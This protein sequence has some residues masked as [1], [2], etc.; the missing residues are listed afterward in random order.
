MSFRYRVFKSGLP[1]PSS[2][3]LL[4]LCSLLEVTQGG[5]F[6]F[7]FLEEA[8]WRTKLLASES[9]I[10]KSLRYLASCESAGVAKVAQTER[11][12]EL[13]AQIKIR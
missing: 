5:S 6:F 8:W 10:A 13:M 7:F 1:F 2:W 11:T 4:R 9:Q 12:V 3:D